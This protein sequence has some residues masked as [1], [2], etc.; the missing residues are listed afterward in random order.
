MPRSPMEE[1]LVLRT[2]KLV[3]NQSPKVVNKKATAVPALLLL[4]GEV[5][6]MNVRRI[7]VDRGCIREG[8]L[9]WVY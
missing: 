3:G 9:L 1:D 7:A 5:T 4:P 2:S 8:A 6:P